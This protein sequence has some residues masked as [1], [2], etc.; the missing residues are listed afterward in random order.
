MPKGVPKNGINKG[1]FKKGHIAGAG[2]AKG[3]HW[4]VKDTS[5]M[6]EVRKGKTWEEIYG[7]DQTKEMKRKASIRMTKR[8]EDPKEREKTGEAN[9]GKT[10]SEEFKQG[11]REALLG[12]TYEEI[13]R[14]P[15]TEKTKEKLS[16]GMKGDKNPMWIDGR[17]KEHNPYPSEF[18]SRLKLETR[19]RDNFICQR[20]GRT[21]EEELRE[22]GRVL[23]V[24]HVDY[25][26]QNCS[27]N[28][29]NTL[30]LRCNLEVN[31]NREYWTKY[32]QE[33]II[34]Y[35]NEAIVN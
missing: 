13:G 9:K 14:S 23:C 20:C 7:E 33:K 4:K 10:R 16:D 17:A 28:N 8:Y 31:S 1:W 12:K 27:L 2:N 25:D 6:S 19:W 29:L 11:Q 30:C 24:N 35:E 26:K 32:F 15:I 22:F 5:N 18:N 3:K 34:S 21:E